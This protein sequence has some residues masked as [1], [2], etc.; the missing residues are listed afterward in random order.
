MEVTD[1]GKPLHVVIVGSANVNT[2]YLLLRNPKYPQIASDYVKCFQV[3][4]GLPCDIFLGAHG[5][6][7]GLDEKLARLSAGRANPFVDPA[8]YR[9]FVDERERAFQEALRAEQAKR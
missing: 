8:G 1:S 4:R 9:A 2:G 3:L 6:Y 7:F 5:A